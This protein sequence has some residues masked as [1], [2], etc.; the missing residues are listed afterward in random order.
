MQD[1]PS[2]MSFYGKREES[3]ARCTF[4]SLISPSQNTKQLDHGHLR[5]NDGSKRIRVIESYWKT[6]PLFYSGIIEFTLLGQSSTIATAGVYQPT[7]SQVR[8]K[9]SK[10]KDPNPASL[11]L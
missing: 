1:Q 11:P 10:I 6:H 5:L 4:Q 9:G 7:P 2:K 3:K 8:K